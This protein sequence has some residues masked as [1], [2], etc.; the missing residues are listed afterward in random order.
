ML[1]YLDNCTWQSLVI[2][3]RFLNY[4]KIVLLGIRYLS[5]FCVNPSSLPPPQGG[6]EGGGEARW[7]SW[8]R[9]I[10]FIRSA[11]SIAA[12]PPPFNL[13]LNMYSPVRRAL[14]V[15]VN[16][17]LLIPSN[18]SLSAPGVRLPFLLLMSSEAYLSISTSAIMCT[19]FR[20]FPDYFSRSCKELNTPGRPSFSPVLS[21]AF[22]EA[23][24]DIE[25]SPLFIQ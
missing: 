9:G 15:S 7:Y 18:V 2:Q 16:H 13:V 11:D 10:C 25:I 20:N 21:H 14:L 17:S 22:G 4:L 6:G 12:A 3:L 1:P 8:H 24:G 23:V 5:L 19:S